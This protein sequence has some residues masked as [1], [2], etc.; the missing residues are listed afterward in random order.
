MHPEKKASFENSG[1]GLDNG[2]TQAEDSQVLNAGG[3]TDG[4]NP[5]QIEYDSPIMKCLSIVMGL[6]GNP[7]SA[8]AI[9]AGLPMGVEPP[10]VTT[11]LRAARRAGLHAKAV[12]RKSLKSISN[13]TLPCILLLENDNA[14][15]LTAIHGDEAEVIFPE[16]EEITTVAVADLESEYINTAIFTRLRG[17]L[18]KR[19]SD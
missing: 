8:Q 2:S 5:G 6:A 15:V 9:Q 14:C 4:F 11:C 17:R 13:L 10:S 16:N 12:Y 19:A 18:D 1:T 7:V 3:K